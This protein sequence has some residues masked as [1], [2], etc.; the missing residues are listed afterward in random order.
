MNQFELWLKGCEMNDTI[1][2]CLEGSGDTGLY[3]LTGIYLYCNNYFNKDPVYAVWING[4][5]ICCIRSYLEAWQIYQKYTTA[6]I[7]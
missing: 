7:S 3:K 1:L 2:Y 5:M 6:Q 4:K